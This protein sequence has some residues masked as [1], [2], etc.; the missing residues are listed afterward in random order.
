MPRVGLAADELNR[1][2]DAHGKIGVDLHDAVMF[3][4]VEAAPDP[5]LAGHILDSDELVI[6]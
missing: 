1:L 5:G 2:I 6:G 3:T 4:L